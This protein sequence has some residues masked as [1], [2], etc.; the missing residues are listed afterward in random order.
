MEL[1]NASPTPHEKSALT[2]KAVVVYM[3]ILGFRKMD[4]SQD[5]PK[6][7]RDAINAIRS[8]PCGDLGPPAVRADFQSL[9]DTAVR[10]LFLESESSGS[11]DALMGHQML[12]AR[13]A[14]L[15]LLGKGLLVQG[16]IAMGRVFSDPVDKMVF[17][18]ALS[19]AY[20]L[21]TDQRFPRVV[22]APDVAERNRNFGWLKKW[23]DETWFIDYLRP[24]DVLCRGGWDVTRVPWLTETL[25]PHKETV[26]RYITGIGG[27]RQS[28][29]CTWLVLYHNLSVNSTLWPKCATDPRNKEEVR[30]RLESCLIETHEVPAP[31]E[32]RGSQQ[33][34]PAPRLPI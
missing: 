32:V 28:E 29:K 2:G 13:D 1:S 3:D 8:L 26:L 19:R 14:Q 30:S 21:A 7:Q 25:E 12:W 17:G 34:T 11:W 20:E 33:E 10:V 6:E 24:P 5:F 15:Q 16:G 23:R 31:E 4:N 18:P 9:S 27:Q 22:V